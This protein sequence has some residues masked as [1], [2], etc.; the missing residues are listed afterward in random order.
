MSKTGTKPFQFDA[1]F[2][3]KNRLIFLFFGI[4]IYRI[5]CHVPV[6][7][8]DTQQLIDLFNQNK[9]EHLLSVKSA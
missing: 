2:E 5:G 7:G 6:P 9:S 3:L 8:V 4:L 1:L